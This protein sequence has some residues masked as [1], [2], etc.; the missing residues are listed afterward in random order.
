MIE[1]GGKSTWFNGK[2]DATFALYKIVQ[3][4][5]LYSVVGTDELEQIG[6]EESKGVEIDVNGR[7]YSNW[8]ITASYAFNESGITKD[9]DGNPTGVQKPNTPKHQGNLWTRYNIRNGIFKDFGIG[10]GTNFVTERVL[11]INSN[12]TIPGYSLVNAALYYQINKFSIQM[13]IN[14]V[15]NKTHW[16][17]GY[18]YIRLFP[19]TPRNYLLTVGYSF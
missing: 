4:N 17:G 6:E 9:A 18:D 16:V 19:G 12:Q 3:K 2:L 8:S 13:N 5:T 11:Q 14:N 15:T 10:A 1:F 7:I